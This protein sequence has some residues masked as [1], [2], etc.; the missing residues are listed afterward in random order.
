[1][2]D[3]VVVGG[4]ITG[5][6]L[7]A[8]LA[9]DGEKVLVLEK[10][11]R[12]GG[13]AAIV[14]KK[15]FTVDY[16]IHLIRFGPQSAV[17]KTCRQLGHE[18][19]YVPMGTSWVM[20]EDGKVKVFPTGPKAFLTTGLFSLREKLKAAMLVGKIRGSNQ[21]PE[22]MEKNVEDWLNE[23][24]VT[25]GLRRYF[26]LVSA[27][28]MVCPFIERTSVGEMFVNMQKVLQTGI[29]VMYPRG[30]WLPMIELFK[31]KI[32]EQGEI[33]LKSEVSKVKVED[34]KAVGVIVNDELIPAQKVVLSIPSLGLPDLLPD[35]VPGR[36]VEK[37]K[38]N[39]PT[40]GIVLDYGLKKQVSDIDGL[41][42][43][44]DPMSFGMFTSNLEPSLAPEGKQLLTWLQPVDSKKIK[45]RSW[46]KKKE[47]DLEKALFRF[48]PSLKDAIEWRR[49]LYLPVVDGTE[50]N[51]DQ[52]EK[53]RPSALVPGVKSLFLVGDS[54]AAPGA[55]GDIGHE[56]V[57]VTY[58]KIK[59][60]I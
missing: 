55:G 20:D 30:G 21:L 43:M 59:E 14:N 34:G 37:C 18:V 7:G 41:C 44:Y 1:M 31:E 2:Y 39:R 4:G 29:S 10:S 16:G 42:Y 9:N 51:V 26:H 8:L 13:R 40:A 47:A 5:L 6:Q 52:I 57:H 45:D 54:I 46:A 32:N 56:A 35:K 36:Y 48:F 38:N 28:M 17:S 60:N 15:G 53:K 11:A 12:L 33:R 49:V 27:S 3:T 19:E 50:V 23:R 58:Q 22:L 24:N 25:G